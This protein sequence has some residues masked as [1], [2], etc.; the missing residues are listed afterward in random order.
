MSQVA[1]DTSELNRTLKKLGKKVS[2][3]RPVWPVIDR[4]TSR[5]YRLQ[6]ASEGEHLGTPWARLTEKTLRARVRPGGNRG[7]VLR[8]TNRL[9]AS[10]TKP[11]APEGV[12]V[13]EKHEYMR[14]SVVPYA[15]FH[16]EGTDRMP[17]RPLHPD[18]LP[19]R[20]QETF[21]GLILKHIEA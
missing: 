5:M 16:Q 13:M 14:G 20:I 19:E 10:L 21:V 7:G 12:T 4:Y 6:F 9:W 17:A 2:D 15:R 8:D 3:F 18:P 11:R 1:I